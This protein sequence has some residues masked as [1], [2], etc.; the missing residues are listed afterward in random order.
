MGHHCWNRGIQ[1][2][3]KKIRT[4]HDT[5]STEEITRHFHLETGCSF[6]AAPGLDVIFLSYRYRTL[7]A[8]GFQSILPHLHV[9]DGDAVV[10][11]IPDDLVLHLLP[12]TEGLFHQDLVAKRQRLA[13]HI[14]DETRT[15]KRSVLFKERGLIPNAIHWEDMCSTV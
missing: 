14:P 13:P 4:F 2:T 1:Y 3:K 15:S 6:A 10:D 5:S 11:A 8:T 12:A 9:A 7:A